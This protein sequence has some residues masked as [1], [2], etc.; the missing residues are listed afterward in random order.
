ML[1]EKRIRLSGNK[2]YGSKN[3]KC[4]KCKKDII[5]NGEPMMP[6]YYE[7]EDGDYCPKCK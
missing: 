6:I 1:K 3:I 5:K 2:T 4:K 7:K